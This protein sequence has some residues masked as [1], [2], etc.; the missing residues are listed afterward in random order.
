MYK[1]ETLRCGG[2]VCRDVLNIKVEGLA[3]LDTWVELPV[4]FCRVG[5]MGGKG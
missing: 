3:K 2:T 5:G 4:G 1:S